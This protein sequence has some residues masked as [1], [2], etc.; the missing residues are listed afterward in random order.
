M[1]LQRIGGEI[2]VNVTEVPPALETL[3]RDC[4]SSM[5]RMNSIGSN[6]CN[7]VTA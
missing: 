7:L 6:R 5:F 1:D 3:W 4:S 2:V